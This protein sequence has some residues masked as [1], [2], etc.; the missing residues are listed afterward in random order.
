MFKVRKEQMNELDKSGGVRNLVVSNI[1][2]TGVS[3]EPDENSK[4]VLVTDAKGQT[5]RLGFDNKGNVSTFTTPLGRQHRFE[6]NANGQHIAATNPAGLRSEMNYNDQGLMTRMSIGSRVNYSLDYDT[7][8]NL[9]RVV[10]PD[11]TFIQM[12]Y[13]GPRELRT[14][15]N[16]LGQTEI[17]EHD[18][19]GNLTSITDSNG[20]TTRFEYSDWGGPDRV[21]YADGSFETYEYYPNDLLQRLTANGKP[22][23]E[24]SYDDDENIT[25]VSYADG[26]W[27]AFTYNAAGQITEAR[28]RDITIKYEYDT[29]GRLISEDQGGFTIKYSYDAIDQL[30]ELTLPSGDVLGFSFDADGN[31]G[32]IKDW[33]NREYNFRYDGAG[34]LSECQFPSVVSTRMR[35]SQLGLPVEISSLSTAGTSSSPIFSQRYEY[36]INDRVTVLEDSQ[37]GKKQFRYDA[38]GQMLSV[39]SSRQDEI[40]TFIYDAIGN[41][42]QANSE[43][44]SFNQLNQLTRRTQVSY[45][46]DARGNLIS[47]SG[48]KGLTRYF[49]N[50]QNLLTAVE[51]PDGKRIE[52]AYDVFARRIMKRTGDMTVRYIWAGDH[53]ISEIAESS[54]RFE[55]RDYIFMPGTNTPLAVQVNGQ[56]YYYHNDHLGT[57]QRI[58]DASGR[59]VWSARYTAYGMARIET[60]TVKN[61]LRFPGQYYDEETGLHYNRYRYYSPLLGRYLSRDPLT[62]IAGLNFYIY[63]GNNPVNVADPMGV[64][65]WSGIGKALLTTAAAVAVGALVVAAAPAVLGAGA[66]AAA[67]T[68]VAAGAAAGAAGAGVNAALNGASLLCVLG[69]MAKGAL[70]GAIAALPFVFLPATAGVAAFAGMGALSGGLGYVT[71]YL[72]TPGAE[73]SWGELATS[74]GIGAFTAGASKYLGNK[75]TELRKRHKVRAKIPPPKESIEERLKIARKAFDEA[76]NVPVAPKGKTIASTSAGTK[77]NMTASGFNPL[78]KGFQRQLYRGKVELDDVVQYSKDIKCKLTTNKY[79]DRNMAKGG[80]AASH[81]EKQLAVVN[82]KNGV[83]TPIGVS[84]EMCGDCRKFFRGHARYINQEVVVADPKFTRVFKPDRSVDIYKLGE[85]GD[86][87][88]VRTVPRTEAPTAGMQGGSYE[89]VDW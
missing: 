31:I 86:L 1:R 21:I 85:A 32:Q 74:V 23:S 45:E 82:T 52:F 49:Y 11:S 84:K 35:Y 4:D 78:R 63:A 42:V 24:L 64:W 77:G 55:R 12:A 9:T 76:K 59:V 56:V 14:F 10:Y 43:L 17:Y 70:G 67:V 34:R 87:V 81:A 7:Q 71:N 61:H 39:A 68:A 46:Y 47:E 48:P 80:F 8:N 40:E 33:Q 15:T 44:A 29:K 75:Y 53:L 79:L 60:N 28:N 30:A 25:G 20:N 27:L 73:W 26:Q 88:K 50:G 89:G 72:T 19:V 3:A 83:N 22:W 37:F 62:Y 51:M 18:D 58:T 38:E 65:S 16:R 36:D 5:A 41:R 13:S 2:S 54:G 66:V 6:N 57:P 69:S